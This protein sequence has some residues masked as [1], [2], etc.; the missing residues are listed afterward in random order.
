MVLGTP[1]GGGGDADGVAGMCGN[2][3]HI[4]RAWR[5]RGHTD[6]DKGMS[7]TGWQAIRGIAPNSLALA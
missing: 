4:I 7:H 2:L 1:W 6:I 5:G 3:D